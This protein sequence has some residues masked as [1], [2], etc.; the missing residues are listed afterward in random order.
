MNKSETV[1]YLNNIK[2]TC[3]DVP[4]EALNYI[5]KAT[6]DSF[7]S[8]WT[9]IDEAN[10]PEDEVRYLF[11]YVK[12]SMD[13]K[14]IAYDIGYYRNGEPFVIGNCFGF[15][16]VDNVIAFQEIEEIYL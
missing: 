11:A 5:V 8:S 4:Q 3:Y 14:E 2:S 15:D 9:F 7:E 16:L 6:M 12:K 1:N 13:K 10:K